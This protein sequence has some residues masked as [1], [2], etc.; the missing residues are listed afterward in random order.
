MA[1]PSLSVNLVVDGGGKPVLTA[2]GDWQWQVQ[3]TPDA[4][5]VGSGNG[6]V[7]EELGFALSDAN[8]VSVDTSNTGTGNDWDHED[9][10]TS[11]FAWTF[12][13]T[14]VETNGNEIMTALGSKEFTTA[15]P[16]TLVTI[17]ADGPNTNASLTSTITWSG[18]YSGNGRIAQG[19]VNNDTYAGSDSVAVIGGNA[20]FDAAVDGLDFGILASN[21]QQSGKIWTTADFNGDGTVDGLDFGILASNWQS[22]DPNWGGGPGAAAVANVPEP[23]S[24]LLLALAGGA[25][26]LVRRRR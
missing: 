18:A 16:S 25:L 17:A 26:A 24:L 8:L 12:N 1:Q 23:A 19:G 4:T 21:W 10:G 13:Q 2:S 11:P 6:S 15:D 7:A 14:G 20:N 9:A 22:P 3:I 5:L